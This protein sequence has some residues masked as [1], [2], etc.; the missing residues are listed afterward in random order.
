MVSETPIYS[1]VRIYDPEG[2]FHLEFDRN[3]Y[4]E[5]RVLDKS[6]L[7][8]GC[9]DWPITEQRLEEGTLL[10]LRLQRTAKHL[11]GI[12]L[13]EAG[14]AALRGHGVNNV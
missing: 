11:I 1:V 3:R 14:I 2:K 10:H 6:V 9:S 5:E 12:D 13:S 7:H 8:V 4:L